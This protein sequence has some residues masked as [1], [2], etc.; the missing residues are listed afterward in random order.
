MKRMVRE[1]FRTMAELPAGLDIVVE[2]RRC[3]PRA[4]GAAARAELS[5]LLAELAAAPRGD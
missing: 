2:L 1:V 5:R 3:P 4:S